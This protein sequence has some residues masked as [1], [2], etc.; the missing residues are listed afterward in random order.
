LRTLNNHF[1][2]TFITPTVLC[3]T[4]FIYLFFLD[5]GNIFM[6]L[7]GILKARHD[8]PRVGRRPWNLA[9]LF[10]IIRVDICVDRGDHCS[11][12]VVFRRLPGAQPTTYGSKYNIFN[13][14]IIR[15]SIFSVSDGQ[16]I[17]VVG[18]RNTMIKNNKIILQCPFG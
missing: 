17:H 15:S 10:G 18:G 6:G 13:T 1:N 4:L 5:N 16:L 11:V 14:L 12:F 7:R 9:S 8:P 2:Y 3:F